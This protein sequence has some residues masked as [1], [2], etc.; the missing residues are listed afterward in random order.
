[1]AVLA[2]RFGTGPHI[3][4]NNWDLAHSTTLP[5]QVHLYYP[6]LVRHGRPCATRQHR[7]LRMGETPRRWTLDAG[8]EGE[9]SCAREAASGCLA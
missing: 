4:Q 6:Q 7:C 3:Q 1:M 2:E 5:W 9:T 8:R